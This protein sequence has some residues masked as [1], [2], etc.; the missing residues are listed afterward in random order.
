MEN[1]EARRGE[2]SPEVIAPVR[3]YPSLSQLDLDSFLAGCDEA[4]N[5]NAVT[6]RA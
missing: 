4:L 6:V 2:E 5:F 1:V 3:K